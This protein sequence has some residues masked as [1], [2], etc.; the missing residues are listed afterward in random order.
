MGRGVGTP[1]RTILIV[2]DEQLFT[3]SLSEGLRALDP[4]LRV[5]TAENGLV[6]THHLERHRVDLVLTD[7]KMPVMDGFEL[8]AVMSLRFAGVP[9]LVMTAFGT[10][11]VSERLHALGVDGFVEKPVDFRALAG[12]IE[13]VLS[14]NA[15]GF[16]R[17]ISLSTFLQVLSLERKSC[18]LRVSAGSRSGVLHFVGG[19]LWDA[20][21]GDLSGEEAAQEI[22]RWEG[23]AIEILSGSRSLERRVERSLEHVLL[24]SVR[25]QDE[26][27]ARLGREAGEDGPETAGD[28]PPLSETERRK[29]DWVMS[30]TEKLKELSGLEGFA[31]AGVFTPTGEQ[32]ALVTAGTGFSKEIGILA[33]NVLMNAQKASLEMGTG[34]GQQVHVEA[35]K[36]HF[37]VRCLNEGTD[38]LKSQPGKAHIHLVLALSS[39]AQLG[40][41]KMK[42]NSVIERLGED[43]R[44]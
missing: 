40:F 9:V 44:L 5:L 7:L 31:G 38:P 20:E 28:L 16:V 29:E 6:A 23:A 42:V 13:G 4:T 10:P 34:R 24:E 43:F 2:D 1:T 35:E 27:R 30:A 25:Q 33:N 15:S 37:V 26:V 12:R 14:A 11:E 18:S 17:G 21:T 41:A 19:V 8:L 32:L 22:V 36:A 3:Q 39:D